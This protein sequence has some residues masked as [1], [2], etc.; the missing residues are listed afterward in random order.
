MTPL[1]DRPPAP[2][3]H[4]GRF[5]VAMITALGL[6]IIAIGALAHLIPI[7]LA[8]AAVVIVGIYRWAF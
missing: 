6:P 5:L 7:V 1:P 3:S 4:A 8:G 2:I